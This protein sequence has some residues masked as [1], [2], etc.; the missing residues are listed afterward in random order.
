MTNPTTSDADHGW[1]HAHIHSPSPPW[2]TLSPDARPFHLNGVND[3][4][5]TSGL[6]VEMS[7]QAVERINRDGFIFESPTFGLVIEQ[8]ANLTADELDRL[9]AMLGRWSRHLELAQQ[10][11]G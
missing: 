6:H 9:I 11:Q 5:A 4:A 1:D 7:M 10:A 3:S 2:C 8:G